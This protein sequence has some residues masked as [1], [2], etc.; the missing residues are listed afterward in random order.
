MYII[1]QWIVL[2]GITYF[3]IFL[4]DSQSVGGCIIFT[5]LSVLFILLSFFYKKIKIEL[6]GLINFKNLGIY[7]FILTLINIF[8]FVYVCVKF[9]NY[10][11]TDLLKKIELSRKVFERI[12]LFIPP[13][14]LIYSLA[15][16]EPIRIVTYDRGIGINKSKFM[17]IELSLFWIILSLILTLIFLKRFD[18]RIFAYLAN[19]REKLEI[20]DFKKIMIITLVSSFVVGSVIE[21]NRGMW[22]LWLESYILF[23]SFLLVMWKIYKPLFKGEYVEISQ[24]E[25]DSIPHIFFPDLKNGLL[26]LIIPSIIA[27]IYGVCLIF[28]MAYL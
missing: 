20:P 13:V 3:S 24:E 28:A 5:F 19:I 26:F 9:I 16:Y 7:F 14:V 27:A 8:F 4:L 6:K 17:F 23:I 18:D 2:V 10:K 11:N 22:I 1:I 15:T 12:G 25:V 21:I